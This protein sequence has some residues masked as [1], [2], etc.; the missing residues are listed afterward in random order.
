M[1]VLNFETFWNIFLFLITCYL[2][3]LLS[4][5]LAYLPIVAGRETQLTHAKTRGWWFLPQVSVSPIFATIGIL[6]GNQLYLWNSATIVSWFGHSIFSLFQLKMI[7]LIS[8]SAIVFFSILSPVLFHINKESFDF[9]IITSH[10]VFWETLL[11][12][13]NTILV[14]VIL[15]EILSILILL[16]LVNSS[17]SSLFFFSNLNFSMHSYFNQSQPHSLIQALLTI[18]WVS[19]LISLNLFLFLILFYFQFASTDWFVLEWLFQWKAGADVGAMNSISLIW[20]SFVSSL[21][22]KCGLVP[23]HFWKPTFFRNASLFFLFF[24]VTFFYFLLL[25]FLMT[26][27]TSF[28]G[29]F[30]FSFNKCNV[31]LIAVGF[32]ALLFLLLEAYHIRTFI[33]LSSILNTL[34]VLIAISSFNEYYFL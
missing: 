28:V 27:L 15:I 18:F 21:M 7:L 5:I 3:S 19:L 4:V 1:I 2:V 17:F 33:A 32:V 30:F 8:L 34:L 20:F 13:A 6:L 10:F 29:E 25:L 26:F 11:F 22:F 16:L 23:F 31:I 12:L 14:T 24:Y 9:L